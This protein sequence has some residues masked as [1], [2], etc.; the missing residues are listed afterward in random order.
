V[1]T[2]T[3]KHV[4]KATLETRRQVLRA[5]IACGLMTG[6]ALFGMLP[7]MAHQT[8]RLRPPGAIDEQDF[9]AA[10]IKCGQCVQV[11]PVQAIHLADIEDGYGMGTPAILPRRQACDFSCDALQCVLACPTGALAPS[12]SAKEQ[13]HMGV[14]RLAHPDRCLAR[15]GRG[16]SG[17]ARGD[18]F[19]GKHRYA[20]LDRWR[21]QPLSS[22]AYDLPLCDLCVRECPIKDAIRLEPISDDPADRRR[23]PTV[24][25]ACVGCGLCEM[26]CPAEPAAIIVDIRGLSAVTES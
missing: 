7:V 14:A 2:E 9:L 18:K 16:F 26:I 6:A 10:C 5:G 17:S 24:G 19:A 12:V 13:V 20:E 8:A 3:T 4:S 15:Q 25:E 1:A 22:H 21:P 11:C 23:T